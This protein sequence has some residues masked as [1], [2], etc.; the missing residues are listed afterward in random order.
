[1]LRNSLLVFISFF[2]IIHA[3]EYYFKGQHFVA[4]YLDCNNATLSDPVHL[5]LAMDNAVKASGAT[6]L[7]RS[8]Y[9]FEPDGLTVVYLL[10]ESHA[11]LHTYPEHG[12]CF[13]DL[14]TC[15]DS[16]SA[17]KF[18]QAL[19]SYLEPKE[20]SAKLFIRGEQVEEIAFQNEP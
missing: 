5:M 7:N 18:H 2:Q 19:Q 20:V 3:E 11:S 4:S 12:R 9:I 15:G 13:V 1:M 14:F 6:I 17:E 8:S 16:C 10:S